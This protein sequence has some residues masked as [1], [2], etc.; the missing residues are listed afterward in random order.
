MTTPRCPDHHYTTLN[1]LVAVL[2]LSVAVVGGCA[3]ILNHYKSPPQFSAPAV[4]VNASPSPSCAAP[5]YYV[6]RPATIH[7]PTTLKAIA[8]YKKTAAYKRGRAELEGQ[9]FF[10]LRPIGGRCKSAAEKFQGASAAYY[11]FAYCGGR[12]NSLTPRTGKEIPWKKS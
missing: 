2:A 9:L 7:D 4:I 10:A 8:D 5:T 11:V 3:Q 12:G 1:T 6:E